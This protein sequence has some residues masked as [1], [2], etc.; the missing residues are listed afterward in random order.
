MAIGSPPIT[1]DLQKYTRELWVPVFFSNGKSS[2][3]FPT[4]SARLLLTKTHPCSFLWPLRSGTAV[5]LSNNPQPRQ[6]T[7]LSGDDSGDTWAFSPAR[8]CAGTS[9]NIRVRFWYHWQTLRW[10]QA[11][12]YFMCCVL[13]LT[14]KKVTRSKQK[15][16]VFTIHNT[17]DVK[18]LKSI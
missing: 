14:L 18:Q 12:W 11:W 17:I 8:W 4:L 15:T 3:D 7:A 16:L 6:A 13:R 1:W 5:S 9:Q 10:I 2:N